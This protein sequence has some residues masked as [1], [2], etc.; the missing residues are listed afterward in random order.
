MSLSGQCA[1]GSCV[2]EKANL[3]CSRCGIVRYC[4][5][6]CQKNH[7]SLHK[8]QNCAQFSGLDP[9]EV[10]RIAAENT[11]WKTDAEFAKVEERLLERI[12]ESKK[13]HKTVQLSDFV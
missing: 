6:D 4:S 12:R 8:T 2:E 10:Q 7:W 11:P 9:F 13:A 5:V 3:K 1:L